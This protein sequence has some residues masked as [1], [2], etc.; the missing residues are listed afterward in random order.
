MVLVG[1]QGEALVC[2]VFGHSETVMDKLVEVLMWRRVNVGV[3]VGGVF[4]MR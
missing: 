4:E 3:S 1:D 2:G